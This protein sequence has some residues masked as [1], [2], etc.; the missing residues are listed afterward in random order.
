MT[1]DFA[2]LRKK[3]IAALKKLKKLGK[4]DKVITIAQTRDLRVELTPEEVAS[5]ATTLAQKLADLQK[6]ES[7][8]ESIKSQ[9]K[10]KLTEIDGQIQ[11]LA[12]RVRDKFENR[13]TDVVEVRNNTTGMFMEIRMDTEDV[14]NERKM[15]VAERQGKLWEE[16]L[17]AKDIE[18]KVDKE[19]GEL[20]K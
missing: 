10:G 3:A 15:T 1:L 12:R 11:Q 9:Y 6:V 5:D 7:E 19:T 17:D 14:I 16:N 8:L 20:K 13:P 18:N 2:E 4:D